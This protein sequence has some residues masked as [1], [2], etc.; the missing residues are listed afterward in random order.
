MEKRRHLFFPLAGLVGDA[1]S[2]VSN[3]GH[4]DRRWIAQACPERMA[5]EVADRGRARSSSI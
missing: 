2:L 5:F 1:V 3:Q 4:E